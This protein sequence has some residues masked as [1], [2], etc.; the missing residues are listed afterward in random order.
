MKMESRMI[1]IDYWA[2]NPKI[3]P[4]SSPAHNDPRKTFL[5]RGAIKVPCKGETKILEGFEKT[6]KSIREGKKEEK[7]K[8]PSLLGPPM[9][10]FC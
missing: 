7:R 6:R 9:I 4:H 10:K 1:S 3:H 8:E 2:P 5:L